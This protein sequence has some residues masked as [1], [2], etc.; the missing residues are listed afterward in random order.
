MT[1]QVVILGD[2]RMA[3]RGINAALH[4]SLQELPEI[5]RRRE[6]EDVRGRFLQDLIKDNK[7]VNDDWHAT[8]DTDLHHLFV[9]AIDTV[10][11]DLTGL[12]ETEIQFPSEH[13]PAW[14]SALN[15]ARLVLGEWHRVDET[16]MQCEQ[17]DVSQARDKALVQIHLLG[18]LLQALI[19]S[20]AE[21]HSR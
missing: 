2:N 19:E 18:Y 10:S 13:L 4:Y 8:V 15:Q 21:I 11:R 17:L 12:Q 7:P 16:D 6:H 5:V 14:M 3:I 9:S 20:D 1:L